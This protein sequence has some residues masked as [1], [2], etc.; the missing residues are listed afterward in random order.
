LTDLTPYGTTHNIDSKLYQWDGTRFVPFQSIPT[1]GARSWE[2]F[3]IDTNHYL[4]VAN[5]HND[6]TN[7]I[8]SKIYQA[9]IN[10]PPVC[11]DNPATYSNDTRQAM[12]PCVEIPLYT[13]VTGQPIELIG[14]YST[15]LEIPFG[16]SDFEVKEM[17][18]SEIIETSNP[19]HA[20]FNPDSGILDVPRIDVPTIVPLFGGETTAGPTLQCRASLQQSELR[21]EVL[22]LKAFD[23]DLP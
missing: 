19:S 13:D 23:C 22:M 8:D 6:A 5:V 10:R 11:S 4:A 16:F 18:F 17:T 9:Q 20:R 7:N 2:F 15:I 14:L 21:A 12:L 1:N 3:T